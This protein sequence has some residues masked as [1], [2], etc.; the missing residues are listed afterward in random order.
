[1]SGPEIPYK[2][3]SSEE[4]LVCLRRTTKIFLDLKEINQQNNN[5]VDDLHKMCLGLNKPTSRKTV[6]SSDLD[7]DLSYGI[8]SGGLIAQGFRGPSNHQ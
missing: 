5:I 7:P 6:E 3:S 1:M 8:D 2:I 4:A